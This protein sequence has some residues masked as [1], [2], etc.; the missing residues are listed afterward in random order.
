MPTALS[1]ASWLRL[2]GGA[3]IIRIIFVFLLFGSMPL[4]SDAASYA[5]EGHRLMLTFPGTAPY[6]W[7][8]GEPYLLAL[9]YSIFGGSLLVSRIVSIIISVAVVAAITL[10][11]DQ[12]TEYKR[13][14]RT[15]GWIAA[16]YPPLVMMAGQTYSQPLAMLTLT[17]VAYWSLRAFDTGRIRFYLL[18]GL[19]YGVGALARPSMLSAALP[20][21]VA[22]I[23]ALVRGERKTGIRFSRATIV[24]GIAMAIVA[25]ACILPAMLHNAR[26]G[27]GWNISTN[28]ERNFFLGNN[29]YTP[30]Y[31][32][33]HMAW[34]SLDELGPEVKAYIQDLESRPDP[35]TAMTDEAVKYIREHPV[36]TLWRTS[37][38]IRSFWGFDYVMSR[39]IQQSAGYGTVGLGI[40]MLFESGGY[41]LAMLLVIVGLFAAWRRVSVPGRWFLVGL[42]LAYQLP[43]MLS[44]SSGIYHFPAVGL[45]FPW[46]GLGAVFL[47]EKRKDAWRSLARNPWFWVA[48]AAFILV[49]VEYAYYTVAYYDRG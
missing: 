28:N 21:A 17:L 4:V 40:A 26:L 33:G 42:V 35:R 39:W 12:V 45:L 34:R 11:A 16:L 20:L 3:A 13:A 31:K 6:F 27:A 30:N 43:Y 14:V 38:R 5:E 37:N 22:A 8:P 49:Q 18:A 2:L 9:C 46:A 7:P 32:T 10:L 36:N 41:V 44:F 24:G 25:A 15:A 48:I 47:V 1:R 29:R 23:L 19:A